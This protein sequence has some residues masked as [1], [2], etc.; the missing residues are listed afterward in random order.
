[1]ERWHPVQRVVYE[2]TE[3]PEVY[4]LVVLAD[5]HFWRQ[6]Y[7]G[8]HGLVVRARSDATGEPEVDELQAGDVIRVCKHYI[9]DLHISV[10]DPDFMTVVQCR[11]QL[12]H[13]HSEAFFVNLV[14]PHKVYKRAGAVPGH[15]SLLL[16]EEEVLL[17]LIDLQQLDDVRM[18]QAYQIVNFVFELRVVV[19]RKLFH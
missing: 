11:Q 2:D 16:H 18:I 17:V 6:V 10:Y 9:L 14:L 5:D 15:R 19:R 13:D 1:M 12:L 8:A 3:R 4:L 7:S